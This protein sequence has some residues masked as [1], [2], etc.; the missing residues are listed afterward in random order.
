MK[1]MQVKAENTKQRFLKAEKQFL[2]KRE[3][4][5]GQLGNE[6]MAKVS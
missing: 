6:N 1:D 4:V 2:S 3:K 5:L